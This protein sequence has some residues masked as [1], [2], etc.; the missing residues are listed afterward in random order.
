MKKI[1]LLLMVLLVATTS[2]L[3]ADEG[4]WLLPLIEKLNIEKMQQMGLKLSAEDIYSVNQASLKDA[5]VI[6]GRGCTGEVIS[7]KGLVLTNHHCGYSSIQALSSVENT[8]VVASSGSK[9][10]IRL[11]GNTSAINPNI[12]RCWAWRS[13]GARSDTHAPI[14]ATNSTAITTNSGNA[15]ANNGG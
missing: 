14:L 9:R 3:R 6:F 2:R 8:C 7:D 15:S 12:I 10:V 5:V 13:P 4:M 11:S 1:L